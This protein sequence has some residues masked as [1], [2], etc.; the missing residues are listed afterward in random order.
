MN[1]KTTILQGVG[2]MR[3]WTIIILTPLLIMAL[4]GGIIFVSR[5]QAG[6]N[7]STATV[8][9]DVKGCQMNSNNGGWTCVVK[10]TIDG[11]PSSANGFD[12][13]VDVPQS[14]VA[15]GQTFQVAYDPS[16]PESTLTAA[17]LTP[18]AKISLEIVLGI[19]LLIAVGFLL[20]NLKFRNNKT[21][22]DS[23]G[24]MVG[25]DAV[26]DILNVIF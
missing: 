18:A 20:L 12:L 15:S 4:I 25:L 1:E 7:M 5:Y 14:S 16:Q 2:M 3:I 11:L 26:S 10:V 9:T 21:W 22:Q 6:W 17:P 24:V 13:K 8:I 19:I 23:S